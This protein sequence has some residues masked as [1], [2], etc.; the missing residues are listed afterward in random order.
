VDER[1][2]L[3]YLCH[4]F[5]ELGAYEL[6]PTLVEIR[7]F[8]VTHPDE[9]LILDVEDYVSPHDLAEAF[10]R[11]GLEE[12]V[13]KGPNGPPWPT[14]GDLISSGQR[15]VAFIES[16]KPGVEWLRAAYP[17]MRE[18]PYTFH[19]PEDFSCRANRGGDLGSLFLMNH[20]I[21]TAPAPRPSN[22]AIV[23][24][25]PFL[26]ARAEQCEKERHHMP[27]IIAVDFYRTGDLLKVV[28]RINGIGEAP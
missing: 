19:K 27:N 3:L 1:K 25:Y 5:C 9:V 10:H 8:L 26:L 17:T 7:N 2:R 6:E 28:N 11:S 18:T 24:A 20:W 14:L 16:G 22:A 13:Y 15:V 21:D 4:G 12:F 23:N